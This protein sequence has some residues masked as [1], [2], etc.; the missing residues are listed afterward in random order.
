MLILRGHGD[1]VRCL[2][3]SPDGRFLASGSEDK[4]VR[5]W[6]L[7]GSGA[8]AATFEHHMG[9][10]S[11]VFIP[12]GKT[13]LTGTSTGMLVEWDLTRRRRKTP[14]SGHSGGVRHLIPTGDIGGGETLVTAGWDHRV[15]VREQRTLQ[16]RFVLQDVPLCA[17]LSWNPMQRTLAI[18]DENGV[19]VLY[20]L[21]T[22]SIRHTFGSLLPL[23]VLAWSPDGRL[24]ASG[25]AEGT[26]RLMQMPL[27]KGVATLRGHTWTVYALAFTPDGRTLISGCADGTVRL[28]DVARGRERRCY[29]WHTSWVTCVAVAPDGMTAAAGSADRTVVVW[30]L[31]DD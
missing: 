12:D 13:F 5:L 6:D 29:R 11:L 24:L 4:T 19:I 3:Y 22:R 18:G 30:D 9:V 10:E 28:W 16:Q 15:T 31:D 7:S 2:S 20:E 27:S 25:H 26:V 14:R 1:A 21:D 17:A 23:C 8:L